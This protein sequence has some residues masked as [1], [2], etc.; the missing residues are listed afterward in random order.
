MGPKDGKVWMTGEKVV[1]KITKPLSGKKTT[2]KAG[3]VKEKWMTGVKIVKAIVKKEAKAKKKTIPEEN[4][5][6]EEKNKPEENSMP[7]EKNKPEEN[8]RPKEKEDYVKIELSNIGSLKLSIPVAGF[9]KMMGPALPRM[10]AAA[11]PV[12]GDTENS[13]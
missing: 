10:L 9:A 5:M 7:E 2:P 4:S 3:K 8:P 13:T 6:P 1:K 11:H 12:T